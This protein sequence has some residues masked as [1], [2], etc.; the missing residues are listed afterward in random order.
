M[1][2]NSS[3]ELS[4]GRG[5]PSRSEGQVPSTSVSLPRRLAGVVLATG[6]A[7]AV[8]ASVS[9]RA[10]AASGPGCS[11]QKRAARIVSLHLFKAQV[12]PAR[13]AFFRTHKRSRTRHA[14]AAG[15]QRR[16][17]ALKRAV[18]RCVASGASAVPE[19]APDPQPPPCSPSLY[20]A[21]YTEMNEGTTN[22]ALPLRPEGRI[23]AVMLFVDFSDLHSSESTSALYDRLV[24]RSRS[25]FNEVSYG[26]AQLD[27]TPVHHWFRMPRSLGSYGLRDGISWPEHHDYI[28]DAIRA[29]DADVDFS[30]YQV[31]YVVAAKGTSIERS[32][33]FQAY[34]GSG[35]QAD[36]TELRYGATF[37]ED[38]RSDARYAANVLI[39]ETGHILGLP[40]LYDVPNP[41][42]WSLFR[43]AGGWDMMSWNDPGGH[44]LA[45][46]KWKLGWLGASQLTCLGSPGELTT[47]IG[48]LERAGGLKAIVVPTGISSAY[49]IEARKR[50]GE[51]A[52][53]CEDGVL[54]YSVDAS[55][56][57]GYGPVHVHAAQRDGNGDAFNRCGPL[58]NATFDKASGEVARFAD[59]AAGISVQ[60]LS[61]SA[62]GYRVHVTR[63]S[64]ATQGL[65]NQSAQGPVSGQ[66]Q[67]LAPPQ[68]PFSAV[69]FP[70]GVGWDL[71][72][73]TAD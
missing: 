60:V 12:N 15:Q 41:T 16:L 27:V 72:P 70:F 11:V 31:V 36:G 8:A 32:P 10:S 53:L 1:G 17:T 13:A 24:P 23:R 2:G 30:G 61:S 5:A 59:D 9:S 62:N 58:Y 29:A 48:P 19:A 3:R 26:R 38:T 71:G 42:F 44:F 68:A 22:S 47:T 39:H 67:D 54:I 7:L 35:I 69:S 63:T 28:A 33:A 34:P 55:V 40:D 49:V 64:L 37:F 51:D 56:R 4:R 52:R 57:T 45:W 46:E 25:W 20:S 18:A 21:P 65:S 66:A 43:Y 73:L 6:L 14:Y 50:I